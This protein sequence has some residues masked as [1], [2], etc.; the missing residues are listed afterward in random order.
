[1]EHHTRR[2]KKGFGAPVAQWL[3]GPLRDW[4]EDLLDPIAMRNRG[5]LD[6]H[7]VSALW[8]S[9]VDGNRKYHTHLWP[10]LMFQAW[11]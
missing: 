10:V 5:I 4:A 11:D 2:P 1:P 7:V 6:E 3:N 8:K 9:F